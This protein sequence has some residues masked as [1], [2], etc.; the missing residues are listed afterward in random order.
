MKKTHM[1]ILKVHSHTV[2]SVPLLFAA[3]IVSTYVY[4]IQSLKPKTGFLTLRLKNHNSCCIPEMAESRWS[5]N[6]MI[7]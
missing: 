1:Q 3:P 6:I 2:R 4:E 5:L 7:S